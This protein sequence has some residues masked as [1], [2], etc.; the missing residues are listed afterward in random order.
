MLCCWIN[1]R[2]LLV[3]YSELSSFFKFPDTWYRELEEGRRRN[4]DVIIDRYRTEERRAGG[5]F[6]PWLLRRSNKSA[7]PS[8]HSA[9]RATFASKKLYFIM[10]IIE[11][12]SLLSM[13]LIQVLPDLA[14][15]SLSARNHIS[16]EY[17]IL[18][19]INTSDIDTCTYQCCLLHGHINVRYDNDRGALAPVYCAYVRW[20]AELCNSNN[21][22][23]YCSYL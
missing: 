21:N 6:S 2:S 10:S 1:S 8:S 7:S 22:Y 3:R 20:Y 13:N 9:L 4:V 23:K 18:L 12:R 17:P 14:K 16:A 5:N 19:N 15:I 11:I